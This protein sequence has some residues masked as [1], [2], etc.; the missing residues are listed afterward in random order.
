MKHNF[1]NGI[2][3]GWHVKLVPANLTCI[4]IMCFILEKG[5]CD[6]PRTANRGANLKEGSILIAHII[7]T[8]KPKKKLPEGIDGQF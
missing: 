7:L 1:A 4:K 2:D 5:G 6:L 3:T 8:I